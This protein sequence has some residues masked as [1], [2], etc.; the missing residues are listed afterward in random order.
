MYWRNEA[1]TLYVNGPLD[2]VA[3]IAFI[4]LMVLL[5]SER[6]L[7]ADHEGASNSIA[8]RVG[9][10][11]HGVLNRLRRIPTRQDRIN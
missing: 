7:T 4:G 10:A 11:L 5:L 3:F 2:I 8:F 1:G 6:A 9:K